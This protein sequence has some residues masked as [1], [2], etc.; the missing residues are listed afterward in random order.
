MPEGLGHLFGGSQ[1]ELE[2]ELASATGVGE[3]PTGAVSGPGTAGTGAE[4][5]QSQIAAGSVAVAHR[6]VGRPPQGERRHRGRSPAQCEEGEQ[7]ATAARGHGG[8]LRARRTNDD[9]PVPWR[10]SAGTDGETAVESIVTIDQG[11]L[12]GMVRDGIAQFRGIPFAAPPVGERRFAPPGPAP[13]WSGERDATGFGARSLQVAGGAT[14][15]LGDRADDAAEDCLFLNVFTPG[16][17]DAARPVMV[18]I[19]GGG[20]VNGSASIP[21][22]DGTSLAARGDVV[23]VTVNYRLGALG[24]LWLGDLD[25]SL[26]SSGVN[27]LLD[28]VAALEWVRDNIAAFGGDP[29]NVTIFG[30]SAGAMSVSTLLAMPAARGLFHRAIAQSGA[31]HNT[32]TTATASAI[33]A[34]V[35]E[36]VGVDSVAGL[37][38]AP[39]DS[40]VDA[41]TKVEA[42]MFEDPS[43]LGGPAGIA[44]AMAFQPVVDGEHLPEQPLRAVAAGRAADVPLLTGTNLDEW[45]LFAL[46]SPGGLDDPRL[47]GRLERIFGDAHVVRDTYRATRPD[48]TADDLWNAV[49]TDATFRIPAIRLVEA[50]AAASSPTWQYLFTWATPAFGGVVKSCHA[51]EIPFVFGVLDAPGANLFLG[52]PI[53]E[54]LHEL[55]RAMQD[56]WLGFVRDGDPGWPMWDEHDRPTQRF[57]VERGVLADPMADERRLWDGVL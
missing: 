45:N 33:T 17:D 43:G 3:H 8:T 15:L 55:S 30:E 2:V 40:I 28:Q 7:P 48:A 53:G 21:W 50:R 42:R 29:G 37:L 22:Y 51:L 25:P 1:F 41:A 31:A 16:C 4:R 56:A 23:V 6:S 57:D 46:M 12:R 35:M 9:R 39:A 36:L 19:H 26:R 24:F 10:S 14:A 49:L 34:Q 52:D 20:F 54:D 5:G 44:L 18:W 27:G 11:R 32:F 47:L 38:A 13:S